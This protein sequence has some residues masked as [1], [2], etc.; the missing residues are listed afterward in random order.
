MTSPRVIDAGGGRSVRSWGSDIEPGAI[1]QAKRAARSPV[2]AGSI[3]L[4]PDAHVGIGSTVGSVIPTEAAIIPAAVGVDLGC[5]MTAIRTEHTAS[6]LPDDLTDCLD[7]VAAAVPSGFA[8]HPEPTA[9]ARAWLKAHPLPDARATP[10][11][12]RKRMGAQLGTLGGGNHFI[13][14]SLDEAGIV[15]VVLHSGSRGVGNILA[16]TH[17]KEAKR[18]C[19]A[20]G[21]ELE[22]ADLAYFTKDDAGFAPY[23]ADMLWAQDYAS[24]NRRLMVDAVLVALR[25]TTGLG[26]EIVDRVDCHHNYAE[27]EIHGGRTLWITRKGAIRAGC[28]DRGVIPGSMGDDTYVVSGT[29]SE[30]S[31]HSSAHGAGRRMSRSQARKTL[32]VAD[33][34]RSMRGR[35]WRSDRAHD[36]LDEAPASYKPIAQVVADQDDLVSVDHKLKAVLNYKGC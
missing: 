8:G 32:S 18:T 22:D 35:A 26:F 5:G 34:E 21:R 27:E 33:L 16:T 10:A 4:M 23:V 2:V 14:V 28:G 15:W 9:G 29:G 30:A 1:E 13:E 12:A 19:Q 24:A 36:L 20:A 25:A 6:H 3:A 7:A 17:I 11:K 31:Y